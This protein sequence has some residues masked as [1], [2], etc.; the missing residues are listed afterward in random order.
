MYRTQ[1]TDRRDFRVMK[2]NSMK[3]KKC[4]M[5]LAG[6]MLIFSLSACSLDKQN[7]PA[8]NA[9][10]GSESSAKNDTEQSDDIVPETDMPET[11]DETLTDAGKNLHLSIGETKVDVIWE[12]NAAVAALSEMAAEDSLVIEM[13]MYG[14]FEQV[15]ELGKTLPRNDE[16][17]T[18]EAG[19]I[20]LYSGSRIVVFYG[21]NVWGY[22]R[23]GRIM[24]KTPYELADLLGNGDVSI[25]ITNEE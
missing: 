13:S 16:R 20:L 8:S 25:T 14:G 6:I 7:E 21:T 5:I 17:I 2:E 4:I 15:G 11:Q 12:N 9:E 22:T 19:D 24:D 3:L 1:N 10:T 18:A 23:L